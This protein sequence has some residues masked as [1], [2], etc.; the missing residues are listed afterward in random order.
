MGFRWVEGEAA[1]TPRIELKPAEGSSR[2]KPGY[3][4]SLSTAGGLGWSKKGTLG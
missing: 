4:V 3:N 2:F 1:I